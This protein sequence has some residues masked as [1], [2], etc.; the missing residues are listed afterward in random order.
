MSAPG[1]GRQPGAGGAAADRHYQQSL[2]SLEGALQQYSEYKTEYRELQQTLRSLPEEIEY[3]AM[4]PVGPLAFFPGKLVSTNEIL[5]LLGDNWF[6]ERS[7]TQAAEIARRR[8]DYVDGQIA[9]V[10]AELADLKK[11]R[12]HTPSV[13]RD[14]DIG[15]LLQGAT[16]NEDGEKFVDIKET[17]ADGEQA[18]FEEQATGGSGGGDSGL[19]G[20]DVAA[21]LEEKR[22]RMIRSLEAGAALDRSQLNAEQRK[23][24]E[25]L[26]QIEDDE[27]DAESSHDQHSQDEDDEGDEGD[28]YS[29]DD[30]AMAVR[31]DDEDDYNNGDPAANSSSDEEGPD[32]GV[33]ERM[34]PVLPDLPGE[35]S[36]SS[37]RGILKPPTPRAHRA[38]GSADKKSVSFGAA[39]M[40]P[41]ALS[42]HT[43]SRGVDEVVQ[44]LGSMK[45]SPLATKTEDA[46]A[47]PLRSTVVEKTHPVAD[48]VTL[49]M[50]DSDMHAR[51]IAQ[52]YNRKRFQRMSAGMLD[53]AAAAAEGIL[54]GTKG[55]TL[56][57]ATDDQDGGARRAAA[58]F[59]DEPERV[60][61]DDLNAGPPQVVSDA[62]AKPKM[63]RF[64]AR[65]MG[66]ED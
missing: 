51:E 56:V 47:Q 62:Q 66:L 6:V 1:P 49:D 63:S 15:Q 25:L 60:S 22:Q 30:R 61:R 40:A 55:V 38:G 39:T 27:D 17:L 21:A 54:A 7:A 28:A 33:V 37:P 3:E 57:D 59:A 32:V 35:A 58:V 45:T 31:D 2:A 14:L 64:K 20:A 46:G 4:V 10:A 8:E 52:A 36:Q 5:V 23:L 50:A 41:E 18:A 29:D 48:D 11:Q 44:R 13:P 42:E 26:D 16:V 24:M 19:P 12:E 53:G 65:R 9:K 43:A 34:P